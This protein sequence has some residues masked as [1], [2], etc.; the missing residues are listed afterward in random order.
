MLN[1]SCGCFVN[2]WNITQDVFAFNN[3]PIAMSYWDKWNVTRVAAH[4]LLMYGIFISDDSYVYNM[5][6][7]LMHGHSNKCWP[8]TKSEICPSNKKWRK[9]NSVTKK[10]RRQQKLIQIFCTIQ[11][12]WWCICFIFHHYL[13]SKTLVSL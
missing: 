13:L 6:Y 8:A 12:S 10:N 7:I 9:T 1:I 3:T 11:Q 4:F 5:H 2:V